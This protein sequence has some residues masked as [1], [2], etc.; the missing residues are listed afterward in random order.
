MGISKLC[1]VRSHFSNRLRQCLLEECTPFHCLHSTFLI[2]HD[3]YC[4]VENLKL[5]VV[6]TSTS[7]VLAVLLASA[8]PN[9]IRFL[10]LLFH[11]ITTMSPTNQLYLLLCNL[12]LILSWSLHLCFRRRVIYQ[13]EEKVMEKMVVMW[14]FSSRIFQDVPHSDTKPLLQLLRKTWIDCWFSLP[15]LWKNELAYNLTCSEQ[16]FSCTRKTWVVRKNG[17]HEAGM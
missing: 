8:K 11:I 12:T 5:F 2:N 3:K 7:N 1:N 16:I 9:T 4:L 10:W 15:K 6:L 13:I 17:Q 14:N